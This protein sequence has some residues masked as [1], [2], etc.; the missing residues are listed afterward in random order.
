[1]IAVEGQPL[2]FGQRVD[3]LGFPAG[4]GHIEGDRPLHPVQVVVEPG[5]GFHKKGS[6]H[7]PQIQSSG[8]SI[9]K[10]TLEKTDGLLRV[11]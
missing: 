2:P 10:N 6:R 9:F 7:P 5:S 3:H 11:I 8:Q 1:M 4:E